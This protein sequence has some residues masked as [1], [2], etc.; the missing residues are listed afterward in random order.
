MTLTTRFRAL[1]GVGVLLFV[2]NTAAA[3]TAQRFSAQASALFVTLAGDAYES[4]DNGKGFEAQVRFNPGALSIGGG[5]QL[6]SHDI[7]T[8]S[9]DGSVRLLGPFLEPRYVIATQSPRFA[10]YVS[11]RLA[12]LRQ[13]LNVEGYD[14][15]ANGLQ[16]NGGGGV[17]VRLASNVNVDLGATF[18]YIDFGKATLT[19]NSTGITTEEPDADSGT[20]WVIRIGLAFGLGR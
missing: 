18:G 9:F 16:I 6:S 10:P 11:S 2:S 8:T 19:N 7:S 1:I 13:S 14:G 15:H 12:M 17:I 20:N 4:L 3:Q 5:F